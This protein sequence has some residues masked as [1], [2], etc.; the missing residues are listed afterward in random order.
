[1]SEIQPITTVRPDL[2]IREDV[3]S[4]IVKYPPLAADRFHIDVEVVDGEVILKGHAA[5]PINRNYLIDF[6]AMV[7]GVKS[8]DSRQFYDDESLR[9]AAGRLVARGTNVNV[10]SGIVLLSCSSS[11]SNI[12]AVAQS[13]AALPGVIKVVVTG[14]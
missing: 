12:D 11:E 2:D 6:A 14:N 7:E 5:T 8:I 10:R 1:M 3:I 4:I 13:V 9:L